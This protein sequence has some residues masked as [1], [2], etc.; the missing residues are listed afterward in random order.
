[1]ADAEGFTLELEHL[2]G[3][4]FRLR[5][6]EPQLP[7]LLLDEPPPLGAQRGPNASRLLAAAV[8]NCLTASLLFCLNKAHAD[9]PAVGARVTTEYARNDKGRLRIGRMRV[10][11]E[12]GGAV[13]P[14]ER[15][16]RCQQL[17]E[18]YCVVTQSVRTGIPVEVEVHGADGEVLYRA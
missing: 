10:T 13:E 12:L 14:S 8:A 16:A 2:T 11:I 18:D 4:E 5:F 1:M 17:F 6:D 7:E 3:Y 15:L 9:V